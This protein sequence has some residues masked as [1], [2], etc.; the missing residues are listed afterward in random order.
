MITD[1]IPEA[2]VWTKIQAD[3]G[4][5]VQSILR[6]KELERQSG[7]TFWWGIGE[8][9]T[10][11]VRLLLARDSHPAI[12]FSRM[13]SAPHRRDSNPDGVLLWEA[14]H[15]QRGKVPLPSHAVVLSRAHECNGSPKQRYY[16][17]VCENPLGL[18]HS[19]SGGTV[20]IGKLRNF[21]DGGKPI[22]SSQISAVVERAAPTSTGLSYPITARA[23]LVAPYVVQL[24]APRELSPLE[25]RLLDEVSLTGK[26]AQDWNAVVKQLRKI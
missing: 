11:K 12:L 2:F 3:A 13:L 9:K 14:Y 15:T 23:T 25:R 1:S 16:A 20:D 7:G 21:G 10:E 18:S 22:G 19:G 6:R 4:Q 24:A 5:T 8:S 17:F 26:T